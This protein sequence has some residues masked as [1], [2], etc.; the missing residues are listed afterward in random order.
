MQRY[1]CC[2]LKR[3]AIQLL[4]GDETNKCVLKLKS[5]IILYYIILYYI[6]LY[7]IILYYI[8][9]YIVCLLHA[10]MLLLVS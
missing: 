3:K 7:Y 5:N 1:C 6:I 8:I 4:Y 2:Y 10:Y 9:I